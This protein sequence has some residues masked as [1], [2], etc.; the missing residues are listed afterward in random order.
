M[1]PT[2]NQ[3]SDKSCNNNRDLLRFLEQ[4]RRRRQVAPEEK[5][6]FL[7]KT[8]LFA[9]PYKTYKEDELSRRIKNLLGDQD[10]KVLLSHESPLNPIWIPNK[11]KAQSQSHSHRPASRKTNPYEDRWRECST[12]SLEHTPNPERNYDSHDSLSDRGSEGKAPQCKILPEPVKKEQPT[13]VPSTEK[14]LKPIVHIYVQSIEGILKEMSS[15]LPPLLPPLQ[16]PA[17]T[18]TCKFPLQAE[19]KKPIDVPSIEEILREMSSS[20]PPLLS[21]LQTPTRAETCRLPLAGKESQ[22]D[23]SA[24]QK[25]NKEKCKGN[26]VLSVL[27]EQAG[28]ASG[29]LPSS[30]P[31][32]SGHRPWDLH[33]EKVPLSPGE[34]LLSPSRKPD[35]KRRAMRSSEESPGE[36]KVRGAGGRGFG[37]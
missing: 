30:Q 23:G 24:A 17:R 8:P 35:L 1:E 27:T 5:D 34:K 9:R 33:K 37:Q 7:G 12:Q 4:E 15:C 36:R 28:R 21:P 19:E 16:S 2:H 22:P 6:P 13:D 25:Q 32:T 29:R 10:S 18:E 20:L 3:I 14:T 26:P 31:R 11:P